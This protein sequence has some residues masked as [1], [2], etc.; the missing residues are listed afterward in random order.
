MTDLNSLRQ[1][2][3][4]FHTKHK[5]RVFSYLKSPYPMEKNKLRVIIAVSLFVS[6]FIMLFQPFGLQHI[7][8]AR[9]LWILA[10]YGAVT[11]IML[12]FD[13]ILIENIFRQAFSEKHWNIGKQI[14]WLMWILFSIGL[15]NY[16]YSILTIPVI[17]HSFRSFLVFQGFT[18][19]IG[20]FPVTLITFITHSVLQRKNLESALKLRENIRPA[21]NKTKKP[22]DQAVELFNENGRDRMKVFLDS[23]VFIESAGNYIT[24]YWDEEG[25]PEKKMLRNTLKEAIKQLSDFP[26]IFQCHR[27]YLVNLKR[28]E[29]VKGNAQGY[30]LKLSGYNSTVPVSRNYIPAFNQSMAENK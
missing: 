6:L 7:T 26:A 15:G 1:P 25:K 11:L 8:S 30:Q 2:F 18:L 27:A 23:L 29:D 20:I 12:V 19:T 4:H 9:K 10:G 21:E 16:L 22:D 28:V 17:R 14:A 5:M 24:V 3:L 13:L